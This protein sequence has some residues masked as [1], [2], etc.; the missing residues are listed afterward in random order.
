MSDKTKVPP[1]VLAQLAQQ[2]WRQGDPPLLQ[3]NRALPP[4]GARPPGSPPATAVQTS[5]NVITLTAT[6]TSSA[7]PASGKFGTSELP[8][9][10]RREA[11][12]AD[13]QMTSTYG[14]PND[15][16]PDVQ[17]TPSLVSS[18][19]A[20]E[21]AISVGADLASQVRSGRQMDV[22]I[23]QGQGGHTEP[24]NAR[25][26]RQTGRGKA[27]KKPG[28]DERGRYRHTLRLDPKGEQKLRAVAEI[29]GVD[30]NTAI[31]LCI[32]AHHHKLTRSGSG[33]G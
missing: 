1:E 14:R 29:L 25:A 16:H 13:V 9:G 27:K 12:S 19:R 7:A 5:V 15:V 11:M 18:K 30:L 23:V 8:L 33:D 22:Q 31:L 4:S 26:A 28:L 20:S 3:D 2:S 24:Q 6:R 32:S 21:R 10:E 17:M